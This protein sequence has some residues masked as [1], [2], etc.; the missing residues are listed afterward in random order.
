MHAMPGDQPTGWEQDTGVPGRPRPDRRPLTRAELPDEFTPESVRRLDVFTVRR[1]SQRGNGILDAD[2]QRS[3]D[4][5]LRSVMMD[6]TGRLDESLRRVRRGGPAGLDPQLR[7]LIALWTLVV[8]TPSSQ[9]AARTQ[10]DTGRPPAASSTSRQRLLARHAQRYG[11]PPVQ[12]FIV[13]LLLGFEQRPTS[14][15]QAFLGDMKAGVQ[16]WGMTDL[17]VVLDVEAPDMVAALSHAKATVADRLGADLLTARV[18][19]PGQGARPG[20]WWQ[21]RRKGRH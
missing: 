18:D 12:T 20:S 2:E 1:L 15:E 21:R 17:Q 8:C 11:R 13:H 19:V 6:T 3:F 10:T 7:R 14:D 9:A 5:A 16:P 4:Q